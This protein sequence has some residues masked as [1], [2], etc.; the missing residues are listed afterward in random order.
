MFEQ[1]SKVNGTNDDVSAA[2]RLEPLVTN[3]FA[4]LQ[5]GQFS[6]QA[7]FTTL[8]QGQA[9]TNIALGVLTEKVGNM[10]AQSEI[11]RND[12][13]GLQDS[14][15][16]EKIKLANVIQCQKSK[17]EPPVSPHPIMTLV[18]IPPKNGKGAGRGGCI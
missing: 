6:L 8:Q 5:Q 9:Q 16:E 4:T 12:I 17:L 13:K 7:G 1:V 2:Q 18:T 3:G 10:A 15:K 11:M 14:A